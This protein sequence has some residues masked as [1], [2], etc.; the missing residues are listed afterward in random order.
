MEIFKLKE[1]IHQLKN[2]IS[3]TNDGSYHLD[4]EME[5]VDLFNESDDTI[6]SSKPEGSFILD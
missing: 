5:D 3:E 6:P 4:N 2:S 1:K